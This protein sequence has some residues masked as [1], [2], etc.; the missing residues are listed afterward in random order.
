MPKKPAKPPVQKAQSNML[1]AEQ[2]AA[3][4]QALYDAEA[5]RA[6]IEPFTIT[7]P[8]ANIEDS[9]RISQLVT[10]LKIAA[11]RSVKGYKVGLTS[12]AMQQMSGATEPDYGTMTDDWFVP[13]GST[14][15]MARLNRPLVEMEMAFVLGRELSG[16]GVNAADIIRA[17]DFVLPAI[18][19]VDSRYR[20]RGPNM[21]IDSVADAAWCGLVVLGGRPARLTDLDIRREGATLYKNGTIEETGVGSAVMGNPVNAVVWL[22]NKLASFG[23]SMAAGSVVLSGSFVRAIPFAAGDTISAVFNTLGDVTFATSAP[24]ATGAAPSG[25]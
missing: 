2:R 1:A 21:L 24:L 15:D 6:P 9:Y 14:I 3:M 19:I 20:G 18:E 10:E 23:V 17:T 16:P 11:G 7:H 12:K 22:A 8:D 4:A 5:N 25:S 13:E